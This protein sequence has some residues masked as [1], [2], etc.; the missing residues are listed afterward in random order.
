MLPGNLISE[1]QL[2]ITKLEPDPI[3]FNMV[4]LDSVELNTTMSGEH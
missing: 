1:F 2:R 3:L 4:P